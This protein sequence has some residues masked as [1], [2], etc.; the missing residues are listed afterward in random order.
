MQL[1]SALYNEKSQFRRTPPIYYEKFIEAFNS[2]FSI[3]SAILMTQA[4]EFQYAFF[5]LFKAAIKHNWI[6]NLEMIGNWDAEII[7]VF[8][9]VRF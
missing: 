5:Q 8:P 3:L 4:E 2:V 9:I 6:A 1:Y 7:K